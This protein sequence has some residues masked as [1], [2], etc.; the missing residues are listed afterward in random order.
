MT[1]MNQI[2]QEYRL[3]LIKSYTVEKKWFGIVE[4]PLFALISEIDRNEMS[5]LQI[6]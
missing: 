2:I 6:F 4:L 5:N 3:I 1:H